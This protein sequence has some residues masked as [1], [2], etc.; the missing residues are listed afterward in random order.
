VHRNPA[1]EHYAEIGVRHMMSISV[2]LIRTNCPAALAID[3]AIRVR[4]LNTCHAVCPLVASWELANEQM[5]HR[6]AVS[7]PLIG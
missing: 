7:A 3:N 2:I 5:Y 1:T 6:P 4:N